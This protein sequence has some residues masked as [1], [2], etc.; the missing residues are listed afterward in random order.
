MTGVAP[1]FLAFSHWVTGDKRKNLTERNLK[2]SKEK[3]LDLIGRVCI[4]FNV[5]GFLSC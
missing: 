4:Y 3:N 5:S 1:M 2:D